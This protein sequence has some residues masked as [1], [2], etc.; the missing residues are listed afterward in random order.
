MSGHDPATDLRG[1]GFLSLLQLLYLV[2]E[3]KSQLLARDIYKLSLHDRQVT[4]FTLIACI[5]VS[6]HRDITLLATEQARKN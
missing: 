1:A 5:L 2:T 3:P 4:D 6:S